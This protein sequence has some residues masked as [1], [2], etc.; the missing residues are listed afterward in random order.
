MFR[1]LNLGAQIGAAPHFVQHLGNAE[2]RITGL[3]PKLSARTGARW[4]GV[5]DYFPLMTRRQFCFACLG[6]SNHA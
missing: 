1:L 6:N 5:N 4:D 3:K 2:A